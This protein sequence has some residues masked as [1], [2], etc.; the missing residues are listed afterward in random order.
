DKQD[1]ALPADPEAQPWMPRRPT[2]PNDSQVSLFC[3]FWATTVSYE[4]QYPPTWK[5]HCLEQRGLSRTAVPPDPRQPRKNV[6]L[7]VLDAW[8]PGH[9]ELGKN[10]GPSPRRSG[11]EVAAPT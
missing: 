9:A 1:D 10:R 4:G 11:S 3:A 8:Q 2:T 7:R 5:R 6:R